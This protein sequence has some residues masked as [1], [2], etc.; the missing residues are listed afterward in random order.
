MT[1]AK[2]PNSAPTLVF[3]LDGTLVD[4]APD[5]VAATNVALDHI[6]L[7]PV[8]A[9]TLRSG[10]GFGARHMIEQG[11]KSLGQSLPETELDGLLAVFLEHYEANIAR[12]SRPFDGA[13]QVLAG[14]KARGYRLAVCTN[15][16]EGLSR[17]LLDELTLTPLFDAIVGRDTLA[18]HKPDPGHL[19]G[20]VHRAGGDP[21][22]ALMVG[23]TRV[24]IETAKRAALPVV[25]CAFG[26]SDVPLEGLEPDVIVE[27][28][29]EIEQAVAKLAPL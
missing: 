24:D 26:Y 13:E 27:A 8:P 21:A 22:R 29:A 7:A 25:A 15:K 4:T 5:L 3:D 20:T 16:R 9:A 2:A 19:I 6:G 28:F 14:F 18:V 10:I 11:L 23:D 17:R 12:E 1:A